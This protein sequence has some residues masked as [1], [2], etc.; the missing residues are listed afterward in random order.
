MPNYLKEVIIKIDLP[1]GID[2]VD[3]ELEREVEKVILTS[4]PIPDT[5]IVQ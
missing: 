2:F 3:N 1:N 4:F 5:Q